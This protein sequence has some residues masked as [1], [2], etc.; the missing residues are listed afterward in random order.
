MTTNTDSPR[1]DLLAGFDVLAA[2]EKEMGEDLPDSRPVY[3]ELRTRHPVYVG[4]VMRDR[5]GMRSSPLSAWDGQPFT[6][7]GHEEVVR[8]LRDGVHFSTSFY[9]RSSGKSQ[10]RNLLGMDDP[11]HRFHRQIAQTAFSRK[12]MESWQHDFVEPYVA[13][14]IDDLAPAGRA[15][16]M[17][18]FALTFPVSVIHYI[19]GLPPEQLL[20]L[21]TLAVGLLLI[22]SRPDIAMECSERLGRLLYAHVVDRREHPA[23]DVISVL[24]NAKVDGRLALDD[25]EVVSFLRILLPAGGETTTRTLGSLFTYLLTNAEQFELVRRDPSLVDGAVEETLRLE[26]PA[27][28][29]YRLCVRDVELAGVDI[30]AGSP[31]GVCLASANRDPAVFEDPDRFDIRRPSHAH[32]AFGYGTHLCLGM[33]L[34]RMETSVAAKAFLER[35]PY[36]RLDETMPPP[37]IRGITF[38]SPAAVHV[39]WD[40]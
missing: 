4:D 27:Q 30:P 17:A 29:V 5:L 32:V 13:R 23:D 28:L 36:L 26:P 21:H 22:H 25:D 11:E 18:G 12:A 31:L 6:I 40:N 34:A 7:L 19:L 38:R 35:L 14:V 37:H 2:F 20:E 1:P 24:A 8:V 9:E 3:E 10:G 15:E 16:V 39:R 33:H